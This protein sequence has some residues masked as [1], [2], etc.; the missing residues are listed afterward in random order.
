M[1]KVSVAATVGLVSALALALPLAAQ[2]TTLG[3]AAKRCD[4]NDSAVL[5]EVGGFKARTGTL[6]VQIYTANAKTYLEKKQ[7]LD[8][9]EVPVAKTGAM[10]VCLPV[11]R[12][13]NYVVAVR[14][15]INGNGKSDRSDG[16]GLS[17]NPDMKLSDFIF[18]RKPPLASTSFAVATSTRRVPVTLNYVN[19]LSFDPV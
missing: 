1:S 11:T 2:A 15:D 8:R 4:A 6:R 5:V 14:H 17:G 10:R 19:G 7:W 9:V 3:P 12:P 16:G 18:K 13:G